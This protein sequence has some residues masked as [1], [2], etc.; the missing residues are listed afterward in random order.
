MAKIYM[1]SDATGEAFETSN[2]EWHKDSRKVSY[3][4]FAEAR[5][6]YTRKQLLKHL[7]PNST[8][9][10]TVSNVSR[11]GMS[12]HIG[13]FIVTKDRKIW[14]ISAMVADLCG[15]GKRDGALQISGCGM[16]MGAAVVYDLG[17]RL[18]PKGTSKPH[19]MRNGQPDSDGG[20]ALKHSWL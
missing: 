9:Y 12:R 14:N 1:V 3:K 6:A 18:W 17:K 7:K 2:P 16:D 10:T 19:G 15:F 5:S 11:S 20:Y 13:V 4:E 8:V